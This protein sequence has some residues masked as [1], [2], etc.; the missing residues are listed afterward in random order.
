MR[1]VIKYSV[2]FLLLFAPVNQF[3]Y[4]A[5]ILLFPFIFFGFQGGKKN[6][7]LIHLTR[8]YVILAV[9][10]FITGLILIAELS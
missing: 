3:T 6:A 4:W 7:Q 10:T 8:L 9:V 2:F 1:E 5:C